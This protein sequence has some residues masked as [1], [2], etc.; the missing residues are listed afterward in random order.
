MQAATERMFH[1]ATCESQKQLTM[2]QLQAQEKKMTK[3]K[4]EFDALLEQLNAQS[5]TT[6]NGAQSSSVSYK[7]LK[8]LERKI[9]TNLI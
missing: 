9:N 7:R 8:H 1:S 2:N 4:V 3:L 6:E 5:E